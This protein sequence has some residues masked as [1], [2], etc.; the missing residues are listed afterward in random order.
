MTRCDQT[1]AWT[2][3]EAHFEAVAGRLDLR[4]AF[5]ADA[6]RFEAGPKFG[7]HVLAQTLT[8]AQLRQFPSTFDSFQL[9]GL[10]VPLVF[11]PVHEQG[12]YADQQQRRNSRG[13]EDRSAQ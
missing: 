8:H 4:Q 6:Q 13:R 3:L 1:P 9:Q 2:A 11:L 7:E 10:Q 12:K 5:G